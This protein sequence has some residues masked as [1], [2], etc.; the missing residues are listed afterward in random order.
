MAWE[1][2][3]RG[4]RYYTRSRREGGRV[5][6]EYVGGSVLVELAARADELKRR[7]RERAAAA[8]REEQETLEALD[9]PFAE[10]WE[11]AETLYSAAL[12]AAGYRHYKR[13]EWRKMREP[14]D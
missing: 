1:H 2:R 7:E 12:V 13:G 4:G 14:Q 3:Q 8:E 5:V 6:R 10:A 9:A 11:A